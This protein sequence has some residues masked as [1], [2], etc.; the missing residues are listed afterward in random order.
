MGFLRD[1]SRRYGAGNYPSLSLTPLIDTALTLLVVFMVTASVAHRSIRVDLP[2]GNTDDMK[3]DSQTHEMV[4]TIDAQERYYLDAVECG[5][6][7]LIATIRKQTE[8]AERPVVVY[9]HVDRHA[10]CGSALELLDVLRAME[11]VQSIAF[12]I[13][14]SA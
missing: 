7:S 12:D 4:V 6:Q 2:K 13:D 1:R 11:G 8:K 10:S 14:K 9:L 3:Q 5:R